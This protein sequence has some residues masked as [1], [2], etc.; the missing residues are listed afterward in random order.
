MWSVG[1]GASDVILEHSL[2]LP[3]T[4]EQDV[5]KALSAHGPNRTAPRM[6]SLEVSGLASGRGTRVLFRRESGTGR[7]AEAADN[8]RALSNLDG[9][10]AL[11][12]RD[13]VVR[14]PLNGVSM[15]PHVDSVSMLAL[16]RRLR[17]ALL[18]SH[19]IEPSTLPHVQ[20]VR[21]L[22]VLDDSSAVACAR[23]KRR[24]TLSQKGTI[25]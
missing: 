3:T 8:L 17:R 4:V 25:L 19:R 10:L 24:G 12:R 18:H 22:K 6:H 13:D 1:H 9:E 5:V 15:Q 23:R 2:E 14:R 11:F 20:L 16:T 21:L 7:P